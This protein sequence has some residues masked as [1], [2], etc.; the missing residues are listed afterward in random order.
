MEW[1]FSGIGTAIVSSVLG[2]IVGRKYQ[3][4]VYKS[5]QVSGENS[6]QINSSVK[7]D[8]VGDSHV[9]G[10]DMIINYAK[11]K[12]DNGRMAH[13]SNSEIEEVIREGNDATVRRWCMELIL[14]NKQE[15]LYNMCIKK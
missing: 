6:I 9:I 7:A 5:K 14:K 4:N 11:D 10:R 3:E 12:F 2:F 15:Y 13:M 8:N 1:I